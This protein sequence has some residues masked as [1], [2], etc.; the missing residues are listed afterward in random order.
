M[1]ASCQTH[2]G[3]F[4]RIPQLIEHYKDIVIDG[5]ECACVRS[6]GQAARERF[7]VVKKRHTGKSLAVSERN[8]KILSL[9]CV[10]EDSVHDYTLME[11]VFKPGLAWFRNVILCLEFGFLGADKDYGNA[12]HLL[13][14]KPRKSKNN[15]NPSLTPEQKKQNRA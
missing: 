2:G 7:P 8:R 9:R 6:Q 4:G 11:S 12:R 10:V 5:V 3:N 1:G 14:K 13:H 15:P